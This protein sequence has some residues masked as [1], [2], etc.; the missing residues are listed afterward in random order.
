MA[1]IYF[2]SSALESYTT[3][4]LTKPEESIEKGFGGRVILQPASELIVAEH[5]LGL[6]QDLN[7]FD[8]GNS[9]LDEV[10]EVVFLVH[11]LLVGHFDLLLYF[12]DEAVN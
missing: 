5:D 4:S 1:V 2:P 6:L 10:R 11:D 7:V 9:L 12:L 3:Y 8:E